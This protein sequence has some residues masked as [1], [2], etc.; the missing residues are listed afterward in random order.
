MISGLSGVVW[1]KLPARARRFLVRV[2]QPLFTVSAAAIVTNSEGS[3][4]LLDH[5][6]RPSSGWGLPGGFVE[7]GEQPEQAIRRELLEE[8]GMK[9]EDVRLAKVRTVGSHIEFVFR[10]AAGSEPSVAS[11]EIKGFA[12]CSP[13]KYPVNFSRAQAAVIEEV[14]SDEGFDNFPPAY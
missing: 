14:L 9:L 6:I 3:V 12:W 11:G 2:T 5:R 8:A 13:G 7:H 4:L 10:A 1:K